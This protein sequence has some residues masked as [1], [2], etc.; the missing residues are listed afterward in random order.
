MISVGDIVK[1]LPPFQASFSQEYTVDRIEIAG[2][3]QQAIFLSGVE[4][5]FS[6]IHLEKV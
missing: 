5:G 2:D 4:G 3:G 1:V 6:E